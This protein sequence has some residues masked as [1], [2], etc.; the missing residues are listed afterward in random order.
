MFVDVQLV[1]GSCSHV[2]VPVVYYV[3]LLHI[4][5]REKRFFGAVV[6]ALMICC[7]RVLVVLKRY[8]LAERVVLDHNRALHV[9]QRQ[10]HA[11]FEN[12]Q[13]VLVHHVAVVLFKE[14]VL[15]LDFVA[16]C[17]G[18]IRV[19]ER[20]A[21]FFSLR[22]RRVQVLSAVV[23][24]PV[25]HLKTLPISLFL[26]RI[27]DQPV[28]EEIVVECHVVHCYVACLSEGNQR[29]RVLVCHEVAELAVFYRQSRDAC[30]VVINQP[31][32]SEQSLKSK[33]KKRKEKGG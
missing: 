16:E 4:K 12:G 28:P 10:R 23:V 32:K 27:R 8:K 19:A 6:R 20:F 30:R 29:L 1:H 21:R 24:H 3:T 5:M 14:R 2:V 15:Y 25:L 31:V 18:G 33:E 13:L 22:S 11:F 7:L 17:A 26:Q 9:L